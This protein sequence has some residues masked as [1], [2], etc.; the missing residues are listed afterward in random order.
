MELIIP[1]P[2]VKEFVKA[3]TAISSVIPEIALNLDEMGMKVHH[4]DPAN[5]SY[6]EIVIKKEFFN[7]F[8]I[9]DDKHVGVNASNFTKSVSRCTGGNVTIKTV[10]NQMVISSD[11]RKFELPIIDVESQKELSKFDKPELSKYK[12]KT[13]ELKSAI[14]DINTLISNKETGSFEIQFSGTLFV[15]YNNMG[16][17]YEQ[18]IEPIE[19][20]GNNQKSS[21]AIDYFEKMLV[22]ECETVK[23]VMGVDSPIEINY[24][25]NEHLDIRFVLAPRITDAD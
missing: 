22:T 8:V 14:D 10:N 6:A 20:E 17:G 19:K 4:T 1:Q 21:F 2:K 25:V 13:I 15:K 24:V 11:K 12:V 18:D 23:L 7:S 3:F 9:G 16:K 5:V